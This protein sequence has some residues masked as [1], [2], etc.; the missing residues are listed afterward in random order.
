M[1]SSFIAGDSPD[2]G[3]SGVWPDSGRVES[4]SR[5]R[6]RPPQFPSPVRSL[7]AATNEN[8]GQSSG[9]RRTYEGKCYFDRNELTG[10]MRLRV[11][12]ERN[13]AKVLIAWKHDRW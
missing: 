6:N 10:T 12:T 13:G 7:A 11:A 9:K 5:V 3:L 2:P 1:A 4:Q 8:T